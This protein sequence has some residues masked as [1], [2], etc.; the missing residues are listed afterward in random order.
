M[1]PAGFAQSAAPAH[2]AATNVSDM[3]FV[4]FPGMP[5]CA[6]GSVQNGDPSQG[7]SI[8]FARMAAG[9][10]FPWHW[11]TPNEHLMIVSG[12]AQAEM[13]GEKPVTLRSG[14]FALMP[15]KHAHQFRCDTACTLYVYSD[16]AFDMHYLDAQGNE[17]APAAAL[18]AVKE[19][20]APAPR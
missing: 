8:I 15:S 18:A 11:H 20:P 10:V 12:V 2:G 7:G 6:S 16:A 17:I 13:K 9:C 19:V 14:A 5:T 1:A 4:S 3:K